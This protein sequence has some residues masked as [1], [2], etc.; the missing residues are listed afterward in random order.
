MAAK[1]FDL[2]V[3]GAGPGGYVAAIRGAQLGLSVAIVEREHLGGICLNWG[4]IPTKAL[5]RSSEVFHLM[6]R[7][8]EFG[9]KADNIGYDLEAVVK[10]SRKVAGQLSGGIGHLMK[11]NKVSVFMGAATLAGKGKVSVKSKDGE[12]TLT[13]K[14][15][16][17]ATGARARNLP[18]LEADGKRVWMYKDALQPPHMPKKLLVIGSG[19]IG[20][21]FASF[22]NTL[23]ADTTVVEVMDRILPVEDEEISKFAKKQ[24]E[25]QGMKIMQKAVV[26]QLDRADDKVTAH[27]ETG[28]KVTKHE[29]D[30]VISA[31]GIVGNVEDLGLEDLGV[32]IDRTHVVTDEYCRTGV[33]GLYAIGDIAGAPWLAHKASHEGVMVAELIAGQHAHPVKPESIAGC[34]Y[35]HPQVA[36]VGYTEAKAKELG[37]DVKV[38]RF[39]FIGNGKAIALGEPEG[40]IKTVFDA[41]TG[42]LLGA[43]MVGAE[44]TEL[45][46]GYVVGRQLETTEEDLMNTVFP[47]PTLSEMMHESVLDAYGRVI[48]M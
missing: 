39:P 40:M 25:K 36:S 19:A 16:V 12:E 46:Q 8:S 43:H 17:L 33:E 11:K 29:F 32:K 7:A 20:I 35:C 45:I 23:G 21:E 38:G 4:C 5:L 14:N 27:I 41:K 47:H 31:V 34:T 15:I 9:L 22:Y 6:Q 2:I 28:G 1:S 3:I 13:A 30:T 10:R 42:E 48:H 44:V 37:F 24:F 26:K 18:G